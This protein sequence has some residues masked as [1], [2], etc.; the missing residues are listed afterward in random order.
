M[1]IYKWWSECGTFCIHGVEAQTMDKNKVKL[2]LVHLKV[3]CHESS[4]NHHEQG[5]LLYTFTILLSG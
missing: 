1:T 3:R 2:D 5:E 4:D